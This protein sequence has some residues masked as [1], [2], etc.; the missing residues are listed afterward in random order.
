MGWFDFLDP[1][2]NA[3]E[4]WLVSI[5]VTVPPFSGIFL[6]FVSFIL[7]SITGLLNRTLL[8]MDELAKKSEE[9][10]K[11]QD[12][13]K[14]AMETAD[15]KLW[16]NVKRNEDRFL[17]LQKDTMIK[18]MLPSFIT[19][20]PFIFFFTTLR[21][22]F[23]HAENFAMNKYCEDGLK[24]GE[25]LICGTGDNVREGGLVI[26]PFKAHSLPLIGDWF[27][28]YALDENLSIAGFSFWYFMC[29][30]VVSTLIQRLFGI[31]ITGMQTP[32]QPG[33]MR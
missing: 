32:G 14:K 19:M 20:G 7:S 24:N 5:G 2:T 4:Q 16:I 23:Q 8:D 13:K 17:Q 27:S 26:L 29:A 33:S 3:I 15:K 18:R 28:P 6:L 22:A 12:L 1:L 30:I 21:T 31:N 11:H 9:M 10:K 25:P